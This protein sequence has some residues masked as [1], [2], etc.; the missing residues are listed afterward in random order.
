[1]KIRYASGKN[2]GSYPTVEFF[3][4]NLGLA[5]L[6]GATKAGKSTLLDL[7]AWTLY[8][9][10]SK[11]SAADDVRSWFADEKT[12]GIVMV[13]N[14]GRGEITVVRHRGSKSHHNDLYFT[15]GGNPA[16]I[17]GKDMADTQKLLIAELGVDAE[18][19]ITGSYIHQFSKADSFFTSKAKDRRDVLEKIADQ[20]LAIRLGEAA[21]EGR[22]GLKKQVE[23][24]NTQ[25][26]RLEGK[27][28]QA[29]SSRQDAIDKIQKWKDDFATKLRS[30][31]AKSGSFEDNRRAE[32]EKYVGQLEVLDKEISA[33]DTFKVRYD[34]LQTQIRAISSLKKELTAAQGEHTRAAFACASI[35][36]KI[37]ELEDPD[38]GKCPTC[39]ADTDKVDTSEALAEARGK[40]ED[41]I[42]SEA[43]W[44][45][46]VKELEVGVASEDKLNKAILKLQQERS[47]NDRKIDRFEEIRNKVLVLREQKNTYVEQLA[48]AKKEKCPYEAMT[49]K[50][51]A[52]IAE[53]EKETGRV[54]KLL[55]KTEHRLNSISSLYDLSFELRGALMGK[56]VDTINVKTN[57]Y[58]EKFFDA[59]LRV[60]FTLESSDKLEVEI[61]N[62]GFVCPYKQLSGGERC[63][64][65][66]AFSFSLMKQIEDL[67]G[68]KFSLLM[69]DEVLNG[70]D[71]SLRVKAFNM[72]QALESDY[73]SIIIIDHDPEF[74]AQF[75]TRFEVT[76]CGSY[77][78]VNC[79][80]EAYTERT[81]VA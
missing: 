9:T 70:V 57:E 62:E 26:S 14:E 35:N 32:V 55:D 53:C 4:E 69:L 18:T 10:T 73:D 41:F 45:K 59:S 79:E 13:E 81:R 8:G 68:V 30:L 34:Q 15:N 48:E 29:K 27:Y 2:F 64:L 17:R 22:K 23:E 54:T 56:A 20:S 78:Q 44:K 61:L 49:E 28:E 76:K 67:S 43:R 33:P 71:S 11:D 75:E 50:F 6:H 39:G 37:E 72:L 77:S 21:S 42:F 66:L 7:A 51:D 5:L 12:E 52:T 46:R 3:Y 36:E 63:M 25:L 1:M 65:K 74:K 80:R 58:L 24:L 47:D 19:F 38:S 31:E 40:L 60:N 16:E